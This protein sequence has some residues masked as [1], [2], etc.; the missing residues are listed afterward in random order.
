MNTVTFIAGFRNHMLNSLKSF[1]AYPQTGLF[2]NSCFA[3]CQTERQDTWFADDSPVIGN[4]VNRNVIMLW[5]LCGLS[6]KMVTNG[7]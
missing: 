6:I 4:K 5:I 2:I 3:H 1:T 7:Y